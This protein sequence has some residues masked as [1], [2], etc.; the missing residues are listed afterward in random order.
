MS[1]VLLLGYKPDCSV[2]TPTGNLCYEFDKYLPCLPQCYLT[3]AVLLPGYMPDGSEA[4]P[5]T[6]VDKIHSKSNMLFLL[7]H[8]DHHRSAAAWLHA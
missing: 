7:L 3:C 8:V 1:A 5:T 4:T 6:E 2:A